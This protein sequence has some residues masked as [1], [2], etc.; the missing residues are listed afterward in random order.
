MCKFFRL[1]RSY[2]SVIL[3]GGIASFFVF[4]IVYLIRLMFIGIGQTWFLVCFFAFII[5]PIV[6]MYCKIAWDFYKE[7]RKKPNKTIIK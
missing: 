7:T 5:F 3:I 6:G 2:L 4:V 1:I